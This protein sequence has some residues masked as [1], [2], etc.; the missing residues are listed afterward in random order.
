MI[1]HIDAAWSFG[2][3]VTADDDA[4]FKAAFRP[5]DESVCMW[6]AENR[7][8]VYRV[9]FTINAGADDYQEAVNR[10]RAELQRMGSEHGLTGKPIE[11]VAMTGEGMARWREGEPG[12]T[13]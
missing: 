11:I 8:G 6:V 12:L 9:Q 2:R 3:A 1:F 4:A 7:P 13:R 5:H 10:S